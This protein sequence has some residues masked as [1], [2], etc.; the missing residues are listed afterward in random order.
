MKILACFGLFCLLALALVATGGTVTLGTPL[1]S[2]P[3]IRAS[4][5][6]YMQMA[7]A[8]AVAAGIDPA[9]FVRQINEESGFNPAAVS[10]A[11][12]IG[13]A[14]FMMATA[15]PLGIDPWNPEQSLRGAA[16]LMRRYLD[17][18]NGNW[19]MALTCYDAGCGTLAWARAHCSNFY[20]CLAS[21]TQAYIRI[22]L[23]WR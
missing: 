13:I 20:W 1:A 19:A 18:Y 17:T 11:G 15:A 22:I 7:R 3:A 2:S 12:A 16:Q 14:Q 10:P 21:D 4:G 23:Q 5:A 6:S 8:D 9:I